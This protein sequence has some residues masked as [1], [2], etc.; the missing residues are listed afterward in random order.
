MHITSHHDRQTD[1]Q[2]DIQ[3]DRHIVQQNLY[4]QENKE[5]DMNFAKRE[6]KKKNSSVRRLG[7]K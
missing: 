4:G 3:T 2:T 6:P 7:I 1:R 5:N